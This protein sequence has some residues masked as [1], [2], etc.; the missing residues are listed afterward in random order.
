M[1][2]IAFDQWSSQRFD[3]VT[4]PTLMWHECL[5]HT[6][7]HLVLLFPFLTT[8]MWHNCR[9]VRVIHSKF[10][11][12]DTIKSKTLLWR[13][14]RSSWH[15]SYG[16]TVIKLNLNTTLTFTCSRVRDDT[17]QRST[18]DDGGSEWG[19]CSVVRGDSVTSE[20][21]NGRQSMDRGDNRWR[22]L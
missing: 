9:S 6:E 15:T 7:V 17:R 5:D 19:R 16:H 12:R 1:R 10:R 8:P 4:L 3:F 2:Q 20:L 22:R 11:S 21:G 13:C 18:T 14:S